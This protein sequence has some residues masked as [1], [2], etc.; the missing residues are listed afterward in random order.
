MR[1]Y[2]I[3]EVL[4]KKR[5]NTTNKGR[6]QI[7]TR[8]INKVQ[9][10]NMKGY[11]SYKDKYVFLDGHRVFFSQDSLGI[12]ESEKPINLDSLLENI[13]FQDE[14]IIPTEYV[15]YFAKKKK[16]G[17]FYKPMVVEEDGFFLG[18]NPNFLLDAIRFSN[19]EKFYFDRK[20]NVE[21]KNLNYLISPLYQKDEQGNIITITLPINLGNGIDDFERSLDYI[22]IE[23]I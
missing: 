12:E 6:R 15:E 2:E 9:T 23:K 3:Q 19:S 22:E 5:R 4:E 8:M 21:K 10:S 7:I 20:S 13:R 16:E 17:W 11:S 18:F 14:I 1:I